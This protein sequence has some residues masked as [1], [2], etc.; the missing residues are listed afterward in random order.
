[1]FLNLNGLFLVQFHL[2]LVFMIAVFFCLIA[3]MFSA[4]KKE[5]WHREGVLPYEAHSMCRRAPW[6][7]VPW[8]PHR[9]QMVLESFRTVRGLNRLMLSNKSQRTMKTSTDPHRAV[10]VCV[11]WYKQWLV[12]VFIIHQSLVY[13]QK[14]SVK[15]IDHSKTVTWNKKRTFL[16]ERLMFKSKNKN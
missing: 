4:I 10:F 7:L 2:G 13:T 9:G 16:A 6:S 8:Q 15:G 14:I 3:D 12:Q 5:V 1:M 11:N